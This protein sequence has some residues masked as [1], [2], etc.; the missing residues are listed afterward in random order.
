MNLPAEPP[1]ILVV[2]DMAVVG[3]TVRDLLSHLP[4]QV[5]VCLDAECGLEK[6]RHPP[7][8][9][10][11]IV[12]LD[13]YVPRRR[14]EAP[15]DLAVDLI[16]AHRLV[17]P[18]TPVIVFTG[19]ES[20]PDCVRS[21]KAGAYDYIAKGDED[22]M[23]TLFDTCRSILDPQPDKLESWL[24]ANGAELERRFGGMYVSLI[25]EETAK[26]AGMGD[27]PVV[28][29]EAILARESLKG[30]DDEL[31]DNETVRWLTPRTFRVPKTSA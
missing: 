30:I 25:P 14:G 12:I 5:E 17:A 21:I 11:K 26:E 16:R 19:Y 4:A 20:I 18:N 9:P 28:D 8:P 6:L 2:E 31:L 1:R 15:R 29:G 22:S 7:T 27:L 10:W 24:K 23:R 3:D 13:R